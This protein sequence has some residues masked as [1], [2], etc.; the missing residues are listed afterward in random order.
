MD[1]TK[2]LK[3]WR[4][5]CGSYEN[6]CG[7]P[8]YHGEEKCLNNYNSNYSVEGV[9]FIVEKWAAEHPA[10]TRKDEF[11][12]KYPKAQCFKDGTPSTGPCSF[13]ITL[14]KKAEDVGMDCV[15]CTKKYWNEEIS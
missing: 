12:K 14:C 8:L 9:V 1:A 3:T 13:D 15:E 5:L 6:C 10:K 7:C 2:F 11:L 4:R